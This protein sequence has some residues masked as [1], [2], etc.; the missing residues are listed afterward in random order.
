MV[1]TKLK[2]AKEEKAKE[3]VEDGKAKVASGV[4]PNLICDGEPS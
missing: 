2:A 1:Q 4:D 3:E